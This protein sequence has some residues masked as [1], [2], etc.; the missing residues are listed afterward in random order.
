MSQGLHVFTVTDRKKMVPCTVVK[1]FFCRIRVK[2]IFSFLGLTPVRQRHQKT[3]ETL[4]SAT[5]LLR[6]FATCSSP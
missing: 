4:R 5:P 3:N 2:G 6:N 1:I